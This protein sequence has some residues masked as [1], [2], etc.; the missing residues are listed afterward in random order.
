MDV[1]KRTLPRSRGTGGALSEAGLVQGIESSGREP[2][3]RW[4]LKLWLAYPRK[5]VVWEPAKRLSDIDALKSGGQLVVK[6]AADELSAKAR[7]K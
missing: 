6:S 4:G 5:D 7:G 2:D 1:T 3:K